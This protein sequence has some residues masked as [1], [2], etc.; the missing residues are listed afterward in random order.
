[1]AENDGH[2]IGKEIRSI[3]K[4]K[5]EESKD[6]AKD[7][8]N[9]IRSILKKN[10]P[11]KPKSSKSEEVKEPQH[12][13]E[14]PKGILKS[15]INVPGKETGYFKNL[16]QTPSLYDDIDV[17]K[18]D[19]APKDA[20]SDQVV[21]PQM[22]VKQEK[23][24]ILE[25]TQPSSTQKEPSPN[26]RSNQTIATESEHMPDKRK[27]S[28][29]KKESKKRSSSS[30]KKSRSPDRKSSKRGKIKE[31]KISR[32]AKVPIVEEDDDDDD[33]DIGIVLYF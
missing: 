30:H 28:S 24:N 8:D 7:D 16:L 25:A 10:K 20:E 27:E 11:S 26:K 22:R 33:D 12:H 29:E 18:V 5:R 31:E 15:T 2:A 32:A 14:R 3:L 9:P 13:A 1:M 4:R 21:S 19:D 17:N 6:G 23:T